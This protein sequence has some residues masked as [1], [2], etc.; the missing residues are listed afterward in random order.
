MMFQPFRKNVQGR[1]P[2]AANRN[3]ISPAKDPKDDPV[4]G[5][6]QG[7]VTLHDGRIGLQPHHHAGEDD[8][9]NDEGLERP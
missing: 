5:L 9:E 1:R 7:P 8:H 2:Q 4:Q 6:E 3:T